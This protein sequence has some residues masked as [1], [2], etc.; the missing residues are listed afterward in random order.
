MLCLLGVLCFLL[1]GGG[2]LPGGFVLWWGVA[3]GGL[4]P[5]PHPSRWLVSLPAVWVLLVGTFAGGL[6]AGFVWVSGFL[7]SGPRL[8]SCLLGACPP[9]YGGVG[10]TM[11]P[12]VHS[13]NPCTL[14][15]AV[16]AQE[17]LR[18]TLTGGGVGLA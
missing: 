6:V 17:S 13:V 12:C 2:V 11:R 7:S 18:L 9:A 8:G 3:E 4:Y 5:L 16:V 10:K 1:V 15:W 14:L